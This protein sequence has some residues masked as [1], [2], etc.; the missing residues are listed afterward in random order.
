V[1][2]LTARANEPRDFV[3]AAKVRAD[4]TAQGDAD[5]AVNLVTPVEEPRPGL[6]LRGPGGGEVWRSGRAYTV[7]WSLRDVGGDVRVELSRDDGATWTPLADAAPNTGLLDW[8][9]AGPATRARV[10]VT[11]LAAPSLSDA[12]AGPFTIQ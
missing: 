3:A 9:A 5:D 12:S 6:S 10:R 1:A 4:V 8:V 11:S 2:L 7:Q